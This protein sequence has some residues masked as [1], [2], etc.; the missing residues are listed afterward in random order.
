MHHKPC[1]LLEV[2][3]MKVN[4][5]LAMVDAASAA[6]EDKIKLVTYCNYYIFHSV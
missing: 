3:T 2:N 6:L 5:S 4:V 1:S